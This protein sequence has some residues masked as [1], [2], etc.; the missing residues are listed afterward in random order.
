[1]LTLSM[2]HSFQFAPSA[3]YS[4]FAIKSVR[5]RTAHQ[6]ARVRSLPTVLEDTLPLH[7]PRVQEF[8]ACDAKANM[9]G[10]VDREHPKTMAA[11]GYTR[12]NGLSDAH[13]Q[14]IGTFC[15]SLGGKKH[16]LVNFFHNLF[17]AF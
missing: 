2:R 12:I 1:M 5:V 6:T 4:V 13:I 11:V 14:W 15:N 3:C 7:S 8:P 17:A 10:P 16:F 9:G